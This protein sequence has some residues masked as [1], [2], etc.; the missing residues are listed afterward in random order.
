MCVREVMAFSCFGAFDSCRGKRGTQTDGK[1]I[2]VIFG[3][4]R[5]RRKKK[6]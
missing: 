4:F 3:S 5:R 1:N 2:Y 6:Y